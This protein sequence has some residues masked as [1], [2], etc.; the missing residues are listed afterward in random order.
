[1]FQL[2]QISKTSMWSTSYDKCGQNISHLLLN[3]EQLNV[4]F[5]VKL[6]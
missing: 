1:M 4:S 3:R 5:T 6:N 2:E